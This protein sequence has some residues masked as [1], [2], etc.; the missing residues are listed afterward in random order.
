MAARHTKRILLVD[1]D[2]MML[3]LLKIS[4]KNSGYKLLAANDGQQAMQAVQEQLPDLIILELMLPVID[5][6]RFLRWLRNEQQSALPVMVLTALDRPGV[7]DTVTSLGV[8]ELVYKPIGRRELL[9]RVK[10]LMRTP[11]AAQAAASG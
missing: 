5:G 4:L 11:Q 6:L 1:N 3:D 7:Y 8:A 10:K 2:E 9:R